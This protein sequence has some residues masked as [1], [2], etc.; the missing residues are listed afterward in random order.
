MVSEYTL[1]AR[2]YPAVLSVL[3]LL[4][5]SNTVF[6]SQIKDWLESPDYVALFG[7]GVLA[8]AI[9]F[10]WAQIIRF[11]GAEC[12]ERWLAKD[13][14]DFPTTRLLLP[15]SKEISNELKNTIRDKVRKDFGAEL[16]ID[17]SPETE[18]NVRRHIADVVR[19]IRGKTRSHGLLLQ[20]NIEYGF[21]RN[22]IGASPVIIVAASCNIYLHSIGKMPDWGYKASL[23][24]V[25]VATLLIISSNFILSRY[26]IR[27]ARVLFQAYLEAK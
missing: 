22:L 23:A 24:Y 12:F 8:T 3:P 26:G 7:K 10:L 15:S 14:T 13:E 1:K 5:L 16:P 17:V 21:V 9:V 18:P 27:Y 4:L 2:I 6:D 25:V 19:Q 20:H 11:I